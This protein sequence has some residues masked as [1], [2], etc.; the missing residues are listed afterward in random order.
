M[1][2]GARIEE[3]RIA[4]VDRLLRVHVDGPIRCTQAALPWLKRSANGAIVNVTSRLGSIAR[5]ASGAYDH[6]RISY[7]M[8]ISKAAQNM[9]TACLYRELAADGIAVYAVHPGRLRTWMGSAD[10]DV[11]AGE[12]AARLLG[13]RRLKPTLRV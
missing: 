6:L 2:T 7:A 3:V 13:K 10:A 8:R 5:V 12:A 4:D 9:L 1:T 11:E